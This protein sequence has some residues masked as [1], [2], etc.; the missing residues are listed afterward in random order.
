MDLKHAGCRLGG[1]FKIKCRDQEGN[2]KWEDEAHN[3]VFDEGLNHIL[4]VVFHGATPVGTWYLGLV[5]DSPSFDHEDTLAAHSGWT[6]NTDYSG[7][8]KAFV[9]N[10]A[11]GKSIDNAG[12]AAVFTMTDTVTIAG[13]FLCS[14]ETGA[15]GTLMSGAVFTQGDR[16]V[17]SGDTLNVTY[18]FSAADDGV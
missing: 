9:E 1:V 4:D 12:S 15:S 13:A 10:A 14:A 8:R 18:T 3:L 16:S 6:E 7:D 2:L 11:S 5:E 17:V